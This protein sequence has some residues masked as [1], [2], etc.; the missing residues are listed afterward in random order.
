[1]FS[2]EEDD[3][4]KNKIGMEKQVGKSDVFTKESLIRLQDKM[5]TLCIREFNQVYSLDST[6][7]QKQKGRNRDIH[8]SDMDNYIEM[9]K[10][11]EKNTENLKQANKKT[12]KLKQ[13]FKD[14]KDK[15]DNL[16]VSKLN[17]D[18]YILSKGAKDF[19]IHFINQVDNT[20]KEYDK[21]QTLSNKLVNANE[22]LK[23]KNNKI[24]TLTEN[25]EVLILRVKT[26]ND[27]INEKDN[28]ISFLNI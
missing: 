1:M 4:N 10:Q 23:D 17:K 9:K 3:S 6:L 18:N 11:I 15:M 24:K 2:T 27:T 7:K 19:F 13:N 22:Q 26:L 16:K 14:I 8:V 20:S 21:I 25:N 28:E 12:L 5:I